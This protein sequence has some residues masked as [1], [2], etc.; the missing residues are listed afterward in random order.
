MLTCFTVPVSQLTSSTNSASWMPFF[1]VSGMP[2]VR[3][4][5]LLEIH[6]LH[7]K[8]KR[9]SHAVIIEFSVVSWL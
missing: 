3:D 4:D 6:L 2:M 5:F 7:D 1:C 8:I 9:S